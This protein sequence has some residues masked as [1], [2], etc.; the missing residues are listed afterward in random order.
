MKTTCEAYSEACKGINIKENERIVLE[1]KDSESCCWFAKDVK[2]ANIK[3]HEQI[4]LESKSYYYYCYNFA[5]YVP[6]SNKEELFKVILES[7][8][9]N[10]INIFLEYVEFNKEKFINYLLFI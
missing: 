7:E 3:A 5:R 8:D 9:R 4:I 2:G 1:S 10:W 6:E